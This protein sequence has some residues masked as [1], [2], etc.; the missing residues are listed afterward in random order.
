MPVLLLA[1]LYQGNF[2]KG[3]R[4]ILMYSPSPRWKPPSNNLQVFFS[5]EELLFCFVFFPLAGCFVS[6]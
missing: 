1:L 3:L 4:E 5:T 6:V 2:L